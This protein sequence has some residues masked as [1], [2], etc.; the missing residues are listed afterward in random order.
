M[1]LTEPDLRISHIR[2]AVT[3]FPL[4]HRSYKLMRQVKTLQMSLF[5]LVHLVFAGCYE[6]LP[7]VGHS[8]PYL[9]NL[10][11]IVQTHTLS[12][13][14]SAC[15]HFFLENFGLTIP[16]SRSTHE[17]SLQCNLNR[18]SFRGCSHSLMSI[19]PYFLVTSSASRKFSFGTLRF[20]QVP[21]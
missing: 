13:F 2:L 19:P 17:I 15:I 1:P 11:M 3:A 14:S 21:V 5:S 20:S 4:L 9:C 16:G 12:W 6:P 7:E 8:R 10:Y 18:G